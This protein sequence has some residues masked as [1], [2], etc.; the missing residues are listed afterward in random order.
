MD[1]RVIK[2]EAKTVTKQGQNQG[3]KYVSCTIQAIQYDAE[4]KEI[5]GAVREVPVFDTEA[6]PYLACIAIA[7]GGTGQVDSPIPETLSKWMYCFDQDF[8]FPEP[9]VRVN[10]QGQPELNKFNQQR[11][12]TTVSVFTRYQKDDQLLLLN[13][14]G[15]C[16]APMRGWDKV[17]RGTSVM[18][19]FYMPKSA[20]E[21]PSGP[22][23][24]QPV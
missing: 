10:E 2:V 7:R 13:P 14:N 1:Y 9:M 21:A 6:A 8:A 20:F 22:S 3:K 19:A 17:T 11:V 18:N 4:G 5:A 16:L 24:E 23:E 12:R 15:P